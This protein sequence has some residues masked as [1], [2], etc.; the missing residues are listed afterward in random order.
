MGSRR[1]LL[2]LARGDPR[3]AHHARAHR[4]LDGDRDRLRDRARG[5]AAV[6]KPARLERKLALH[7]VLPRHSRPRPAALLELRWSGLPEDPPRDP[8]VPSVHARGCELAHH[9]VHGG[10]PRLGPERGRV[11]G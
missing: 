5:D 10:D 8:V 4:D 7:L 1:P 3:A 2:P 11:H 6:A 9:A